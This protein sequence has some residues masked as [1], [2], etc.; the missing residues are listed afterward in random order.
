MKTAKYSFFILSMVSLCLLVV[1]W[2]YTPNGRLD[3]K[4]AI[5]LKYMSVMK[6]DLFE[7][8]RSVQQVRAFSDES[9]CILHS[10][11]VP[12]KQIND[13]TLPGPSGPVPIRVYA[14]KE[15]RGLPIVIY[16]HGGGWMMGSVDTHDNTCRSIAKKAGVI[17]IAPDY[18]LAPEKPYPKGLDDVYATLVWGWK[19]ATELGGDPQKIFIAGDSAGGNLAAATA[20]RARDSQGPPLAGQI[21]IYPALNLNE[22]N[23]GSYSMFSDGY[24]LTRRYMEKFRA[25]YVP[26]PVDRLSPMVSPLLAPDLKNL[27]PA[28]IVTAQ[29]DVLR[30][31][32]NDYA[33]RLKKNGIMVN[34]VEVKGVI[35]GFLKMDGVLSQANE[36]IA[37]IAL[38]IGNVVSK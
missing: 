5:L 24:Y 30:D 16:C 34:M 19:N 27:P 33:H 15:E 22:F 14:D 23:T 32:G 20:I 35:H 28:F 38:F 10:A 12:V 3:I 13:R 26:N 1:S 31:E 36:I 6:I 25:C 29:F 7:E 11:A 37:D 9:S 18:G 21:L 17:V 8:G 4:I 2:T